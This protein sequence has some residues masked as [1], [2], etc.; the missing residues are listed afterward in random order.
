MLV[1]NVAW[2]SCL[3]AS[4]YQTTWKFHFCSLNNITSK[5]H[6]KWLHK[7]SLIFFS[8]TVLY[9][10]LLFSLHVAVKGECCGV[11]SIFSQS[12][13]SVFS[14]GNGITSSGICLWF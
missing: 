7:L 13:C 4:F 8:K 12:F 5:R 9:E 11:F 6:L 14:R 3:S 2:N 10:L 1:K